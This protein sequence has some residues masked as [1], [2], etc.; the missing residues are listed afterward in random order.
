[1]KVESEPPPVPPSQTTGRLRADAPHRRQ[2]WERPLRSRHAPA[3]RHARPP[4]RNPESDW[5][6]RG[7]VHARTTPPPRPVQMPLQTVERAVLEHHTHDVV[8][9]VRFASHDQISTPLRDAIMSS[10]CPSHVFSG[11]S[12]SV[13]RSPC[14]AAEPERPPPA[15]RSTHAAPTASSTPASGPAT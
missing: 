8:K 11:C 9:A 13:C 14:A 3:S 7:R 6:G 5:T 10:A 2:G 15:P 4:V 12:T 1:V